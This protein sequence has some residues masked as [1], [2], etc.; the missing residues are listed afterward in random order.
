MRLQC[1]KCNAVND[2]AEETRGQSVICGHCGKMLEVPL[3]SV[4][5]WVVFH[6]FAIRKI[7]RRGSDGAEVIAHQISLDRSV[8]LKILDEELSANADYVNLFLKRARAAGRLNHPNIVPLYLVAKEYGLYFLA[9]ENI[10][11]QNLRDILTRE[12]R[13]DLSA[14]SLFQQIAEALDYAWRTAHLLHG[15]LKPAYI[16]VTDYG[17]A[18]LADIGVAHIDL[19]DEPDK[20]KGT[21]QYISPEQILGEPTD[22]RS[23]I[24]SLGANLYQCLTGRHPFVGETTIDVFQQHLSAPLQSPGELDPTIP[25]IVCQVIAKMMAKNPDDRY[26]DCETLSGDLLR[27]MQGG[28]PPYASEHP[29]PEVSAGEAP[30]E[31]EDAEPLP[32]AM[33]VAEAP[34]QEDEDDEYPEEDAAEQDDY[35]GDEEE[36][37]EQQEAPAVA[38]AVVKKKAGPAGAK[39]NLKVGKKNGRPMRL[40]L[41]TK[42]RPS[43]DEDEE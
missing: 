26:P 27:V 20:I 22:I 14:L 21:P 18:K 37:D 5:Q 30:G 38:K 12:K 33:P 9:R 3:K 1:G 40:K 29:P 6:D 35:E 8:V 25:D 23:D 11:M 17:V 4:S 10:E 43:D 31:A 7:L 2:L 24:Y 15:N 32:K 28:P 36:E 19:G 13:I 41:K 42:A 39:G 16:N 34:E